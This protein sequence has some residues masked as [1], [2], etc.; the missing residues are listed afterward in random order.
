MGFRSTRRAG[1]ARGWMSLAIL[2]LG[3][4]A[5]GVL[6]RAAGPGAFPSPAAAPAHLARTRAPRPPTPVQRSARAQAADNESGRDGHAGADLV[7]A[8]PAG[9]PACR[10]PERA[11]GYEGPCPAFP[12]GCAVNGSRPRPPPG[13]LA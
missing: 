9:A 8:R 3:L 5:L 2:A 1:W 12:S 4:F 11:D 10:G 7:P 13:R 6:G